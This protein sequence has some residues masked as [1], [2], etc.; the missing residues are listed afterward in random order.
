MDNFFL[1]KFGQKEHLDLLLN[2]GQLFFSSLER[3]RDMDGSEEIKDLNE[4]VSKVKDATGGVLHVKDPETGEL[5]KL[6]VITSGKTRWHNS[7]TESVR[8]FC[9]YMHKIDI[10]DFPN[11]M[12]SLP[13]DLAENMGYDHCLIITNP[14]GFIL[15]VRKYLTDQGIDFMDAPVEYVDKEKFE[16]E[17]LPHHK[18]L[19]YSHQNEFRI[20]AVM[21]HADDTC[22]IEIGSLQGMGGIIQTNEVHDLVINLVE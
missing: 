15:K 12:K 10:K 19:R 13:T 18:D 20:G 2:K 16:G 11:P 5:V 7:N 8:I 4:G 17:L 3:F 9:T 1:L 14:R 21:P 6:G 22:Q